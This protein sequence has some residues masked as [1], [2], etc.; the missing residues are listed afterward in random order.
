M[1]LT[2]R[3]LAYWDSANTTWAVENNDIEILVGSSSA[4][5]RLKDTLAVINGGPIEMSSV[6]NPHLSNPAVSRS[7]PALSGV[8]MMKKGASTILVFRMTGSVAIDMR[9]YSLS[10]KVLL[11][12]NRKNLATGENHITLQ[13]PLPSVGIYLLAGNVGESLFAAKCCVR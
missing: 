2:P 6:V 11:R 1:A 5:I 7:K 13:N 8:Q 10:G 3:Y 9:I 12:L 4:D